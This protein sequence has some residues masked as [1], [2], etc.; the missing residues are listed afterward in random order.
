MCGNP[1]YAEPS[2][3]PSKGAYS[4]AFNVPVAAARADDGLCGPEALLFHP[5]DGLTEAAKGIGKGVWS[6]LA[7]ASGGI[8]V[9]GLAAQLLGSSGW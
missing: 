5:L 6:V 2:F 4:E 7:Y 1:A 8:I 3:E 9:L